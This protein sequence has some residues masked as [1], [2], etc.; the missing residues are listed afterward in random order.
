[1]PASK[2]DVE[3]ARGLLGGKG[4]ITEYIVRLGISVENTTWAEV[5][6]MHRAP[7]SNRT[8]SKVDASNRTPSKVD[9]GDGL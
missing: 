6:A 8:P 9:A 4:H 1:M 5:A 7:P 3:A 2:E